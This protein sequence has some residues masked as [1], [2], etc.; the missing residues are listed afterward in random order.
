MMIQLLRKIHRCLYLA[1]VLFFFILFYPFLAVLA[2]DFE[3]NFHR[4]AR[5]RRIIGFLSSTFVGVFYRFRYERPIDWTKPHIICANHTSNLD[6]TAMVLLCPSDFSFMGKIE[7]LNNP[8][9]GMFF[10][11]IDIP[12]DRQSRISAFKA[13]KRADDNLRNGRSMVIFPEGHIGEEFPPHLYTFKNGPFKLAIETQVSIIPVIIHNA[14]KIFWDGAKTFGSRP[15]I[16]E[17]E[18]LTP[19]ATEGLPLHHADQLRDRVH[20]L[21][22]KHWNKTGGL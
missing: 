5:C 7:L 6:I 8:V 21:I 2:K 17:V 19:I 16:I 14:W 12:L 11:T 13:F 1:S 10:K 18:V 22:K 15:G 4:I 9:T 20:Q 3:R